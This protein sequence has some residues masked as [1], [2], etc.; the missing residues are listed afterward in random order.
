[1]GATFPTLKSVIVPPPGHVYMEADWKQAEMFALAA[2][3]GDATMLGALRTPGKDLHDL[4]AITAFKIQV[5]DSSGVLVPEEYLLNLAAADVEKYGTCE[6][7]DFE[8]FQKTLLYLDQRGKQLPRKVFKNT[9]RVSS[10]SLN[11]GI[12]LLLW[13]K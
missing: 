13:R 9:L 10:K 11:F 6:G 8:A 7:H 4:T 2:L 3:S 12:P 1:V 5:L